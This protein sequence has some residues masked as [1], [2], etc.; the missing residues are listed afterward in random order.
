MKTISLKQAFR[1]TAVTLFTLSCAA[2]IDASYDLTNVD[3]TIQVVD[4][5]LKFPTSSLGD[6]QLKNI[7]NLA[8][9][10]PISKVGWGSS[11][12]YFLDIEA[13]AKTTPINI[14]E[15]AIPAPKINPF[16]ERVDSTL[17]SLVESYTSSVKS[18]KA[19]IRSAAPASNGQALSD[20]FPIH[21][22]LEK[23]IAKINLQWSSK[24]NEDLVGLSHIE[25]EPALMEFEAHLEHSDVLRSAHFDSL[26]IVLPNGI[27]ID[28]D[29]YLVHHIYKD[30]I[31][32]NRRKTVEEVEEKKGTIIK[33]NDGSVKVQFYE[34]EAPSSVLDTPMKIQVRIKGAAVVNSYD[35]KT[36]DFKFIPD[37]NQVGIDSQI[38]VLGQIRIEENDLD[39]DAND[40]NQ[41]IPR[42]MAFVGGGEFKND[43]IVKS[44]SGSL[45]HKIDKI[46]DIELNNL[47]DFLEGDDVNL[48]LGAP[49]LILIANTDLPTKATLSSVQID[50]FRNGE[51]TVKALKTGCLELDGAEGSKLIKVI[52]SPEA[53]MV[54][55]PEDLDNGDYVKTAPLNVKNFGEL[56]QHVPDKIRF[57]GDSA[58]SCIYVALPDCKNVN[59]R[60]DYYVNFGYRIYCPLSFGPEFQIS[61]RETATDFNIGAAFDNVDVDFISLDATAIADVPLALNLALT[62]IDM[63]GKDISS[64]LMIE[65]YTMTEA[66]TYEKSQM[67]QLHIRAKADGAQCEDHIRIIIRNN[68]PQKGLKDI[69]G[70][71]AGRQQLNGLKFAVTLNEPQS[72]RDILNTQSS[73]T[74]KDIKLG[75]GKI[76][77]MGNK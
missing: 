39:G 26:A 28:E 57:S 48:D 72:S 50:G 46:N 34:G 49:Q 7:V 2:C 65:Y 27:E 42:G 33:G 1:A 21:C 23:A 68:N 38:Q 13:M 32:N 10:G 16:R 43:L 71:S 69:L 55:Y 20:I 31:V 56:I 5:A 77:L 60:K 74:L 25:I 24:I 53:Q 35:N 9:S 19:R 17:R 67:Q 62:P 37:M 64:N 66:G 12:S 70:S 59:I 18:N 63:D 14:P 44:F 40:M 11:E 61:Y 73:L 51:H 4:T 47:P 52:K 30:V 75:V 15:I 54:Y 3:T 6:I 41:L 76:T 58:D 8:D 36:S 22:S 29:I 45:R